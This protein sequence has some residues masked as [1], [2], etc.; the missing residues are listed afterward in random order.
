MPVTVAKSGKLV[1]PWVI[2]LRSIVTANPGRRSWSLTGHRGT[3]KLQIRI[4]TSRPS[5]KL[6]IDW[7]EASVPDIIRICDAI[8]IRLE[9]GDNLSEAAEAVFRTKPHQLIAVGA[10]AEHPG[11]TGDWGNAV[12]K[13]RDQ[14]LNHG[15]TIKPETWNL[16]YEPVL[17]DALF[18]LKS[19]SPPTAPNNLIEACIKKWDP[20]S[21]TREI[22]AQNL[23]QFL[24]YCVAREGFSLIW[25]PPSSLAELIG[26]PPSGSIK[27]E[28]AT[29]TDAE[30]I[31][32]LESFPQD[33]SGVRWTEAIHLMAL[34]GLRPIE[35]LHL[36]VRV[37]KASGQPHWWCSYQKRSGGGVTHPRRLYPL[38]LRTDPD[39]NHETNSNDVLLHRW[40]SGKVVLPSLGSGTSPSDCIATYLDRRPVWR[41]LKT[42]QKAKGESLSP[43]SLRHSYSLRGH[44]LG[45]D[46][47]SMAMAMGHTLECHLREYR[48][49]S[50]ASTAEAFARATT[51]GTIQKKVAHPLS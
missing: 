35:L 32:L 18:L 4:G 25:T 45:I 6:P 14:K 15:N 43:Y 17:K 39:M 27:R 48:W 1:E 44:C 40:R 31:Q 24:K 38:P 33:E 22:R 51:N 36:S 50:S 34:L 7:C 41:A 37:D 28:A 19:S 10:V 13:F 11:I 5:V 49:A 20:G 16:K 21:R 12:E 8:A 47:G 23:A 46:A 29:L 26:R 30:I 42:D 3:V 2:R 9:T